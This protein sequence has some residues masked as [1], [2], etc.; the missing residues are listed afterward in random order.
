[1]AI[2]KT[3]ER[4]SPTPPPQNIP[5]ELQEWL[6]EEFERLSTASNSAL[7]SIEASAGYGGIDN[8]PNIVSLND[9]DTT[10][11]VLQAFEGA[12][13]TPINVTQNV[14]GNSISIDATGIWNFQ[15]SIILS[16]TDVNRGRIYQTEIYN[17]TDDI[18]VAST[19]VYVGRNQDGS[20][21][22]IAFMLTVGTGVLGKQL[23]LRISSSDE[24][25]ESVEQ[26]RLVFHVDRIDI[27]RT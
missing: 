24:L 25:F 9:I 7:D 18:I 23:Q 10:K 6:R 27:D 26:R 2:T 5:L 3:I 16:F 20:N 1:M 15:G 14:P 22:S 8:I 4:F 19:D 13:D 17:L 11:Q 21:W 12:V